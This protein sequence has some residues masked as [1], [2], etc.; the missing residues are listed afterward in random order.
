MTGGAMKPVGRPA[1]YK[2]DRNPYA[3]LLNARDMSAEHSS[4]EASQ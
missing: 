1:S 3:R 2:F 4:H